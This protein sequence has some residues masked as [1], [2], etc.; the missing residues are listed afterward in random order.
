MTV[1]LDPSGNNENVNS[2]SL[3]TP[4][5]L[6][7]SYDEPLSAWCNGVQLANSSVFVDTH[8]N[9]LAA[10]TVYTRTDGR[11]AESSPGIEE[12]E[13][14]SRGNSPTLSQLR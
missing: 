2:G 11:Q 5:V 1:P 9:R 13:Q 12:E 6:L 4:A 3:S 8:Q 14:G 10:N 7:Q